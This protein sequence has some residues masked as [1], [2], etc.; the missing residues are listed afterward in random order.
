MAVSFITGA[1]SVTISGTPATPRRTAVRKAQPRDWSLGG[2]FYLYDRGVSIIEHRLLF[3]RQ[4][5]S[6]VD[7]V[8]DFFDTS[9]RG[10]MKQ[11]VFREGD[12]DRLVTLSGGIETR[13][14]YPGRFSL[15]LTLLEAAYPGGVGL[16]D[17]FGQ[18]LLDRDGNV[19]LG[20]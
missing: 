18:T 9:V 15:G 3:S 10:G 20:M 17:T 7:Q 13:E 5:K 16:L 8:N 6:V 11:F 14:Q 2:V 12:T 19:I 4:T 1:G